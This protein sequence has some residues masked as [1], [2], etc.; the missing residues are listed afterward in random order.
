VIEWTSSLS[1]G[2]ERVDAQHLELVKA[3]NSLQG[4]ME[5][6]KGSDQ[7]LSTLRFLGDYARKHFSTEESLMRIHD[8]PGLDEH[9]AA[10]EA[11]RAEVAKLLEETEAARHRIAKTMQ[12]SRALLDWMFTHIGEMDRKM[13]AY[14]VEKG[15]R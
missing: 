6:G 7:V 3:F 5:E 12:V 1:V 15:A 10:H 8:Y 4:A 13:G 2:V 9:R 14:L 11:F